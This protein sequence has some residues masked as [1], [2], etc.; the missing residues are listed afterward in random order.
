MNKYGE[1]SCSK[2]SL[3]SISCTYEQDMITYTKS[4]L[5]INN[6]LM[7]TNTIVNLFHLIENTKSLPGY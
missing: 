4:C 1:S 5:V 6:Y 3:L 2:I 7:N